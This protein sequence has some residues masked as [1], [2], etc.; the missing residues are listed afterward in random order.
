MF[1]KYI[2]LIICSVLILCIILIACQ[3]S[4]YF[5]YL[6]FIIGF[7]NA[8]ITYFI[9]SKMDNK[10]NNKKSD[11]NEDEEKMLDYANKLKQLIKNVF[12]NEENKNEIKNGRGISEKNFDSINF[13]P[14]LS[15]SRLSDSRLSDARPSNKNYKDFFY[16]L[17][18]KKHITK[19][20]EQYID[21]NLGIGSQKYLTDRSDR[22]LNIYDGQITILK[23]TPLQILNILKIFKKKFLLKQN[24]NKEKYTELCKTISTIKENNKNIVLTNLDIYKLLKKNTTF[25]KDVIK[26]PLV[27][28]EKRI[29][30]PYLKLY[31]DN[32]SIEEVINKEYKFNFK[33]EMVEDIISSNNIDS[34][35]AKNTINL[36]KELNFDWFIKMNTYVANL[37]KKEHLILRSYTIWGDQYSN[38]YLQHMSKYKNRDSFNENKDIF[39]KDVFLNDLSKKSDPNG[40][41][42]FPLFYSMIEIILE[43]YTGNFEDFKENYILSDMIDETIKNLKVNNL[44]N[45]ISVSGDIIKDFIT[46]I[47]NFI[48]LSKKTNTIEDRYDIVYSRLI[49]IINLFSFEKFWTFVIEN[50][51]LS[52]NNIILNAP[53]VISPFYV[54]RGVNN[55]YI[56]AGKDVNYISKLNTFTSTSLILDRALR[57]MSSN[58]S[59]LYRYLILPN[60]RCIFLEQITEFIGEMEILLPCTGYIYQVANNGLYTTN[61]I[62]DTKI[63]KNNVREI[64]YIND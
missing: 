45:N 52:L 43:K 59:Y 5:I 46:N 18:T 12:Y 29:S 42:F 1:N 35:F 40:K 30:Y 41:Y 25:I 17:F 24:D 37:S 6:V 21:P 23:E 57:F 20:N 54:Y 15:D 53:P 26:G 64:V 22:W 19:N 9:K 62:C 49:Y 33:W 7:V 61:T 60:T 16:E 55:D 14:R 56:K 44:I 32:K 34:K 31:K 39:N 38:R 8:I 50:Y 58:N 2:L 10:L 4:S 48:K 36:S 63:S 51:I 13:D 11:D 28:E 27:Y 47:F 3:N